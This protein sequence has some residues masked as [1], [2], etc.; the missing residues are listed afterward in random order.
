M[1]ILKFYQSEHQRLRKVRAAVAAA[2]AV[3]VTMAVMMTTIKV[4]VIVV[5]MDVVIAVVTCAIVAAAAAV[6]VVKA[7]VVKV[8][9]VIDAPIMDATMD[10]KDL[11]DAVKQYFVLFFCQFSFFFSLYLLTHYTLKVV[12]L[13]KFYE[14]KD[15]ELNSFSY[16]NHFCDFCTY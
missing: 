4:D 6:A 5:V 10:V 8:A 1:K 2:A 15:C 12:K 13:I 9:A 14:T 11:A 3:V 7:A 16:N